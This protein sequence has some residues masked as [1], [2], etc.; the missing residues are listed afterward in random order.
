MKRF[1]IFGLIFVILISPKICAADAPRKIGEFV[2]G[3]KI[4]DHE[5]RVKQETVLPVRYLETLKEVEAK[6]IWGYKT[7]LIYYGTCIEPSR[8]VRIEFKYADYSIEFYEALL[9]RFKR[10]F[11]EPDEWRGDPFHIVIGWKW[12]FTDKDNN[13]ISLVL[14][15][16]IRDEEEKKGNYIKLTMWNLLGKEKRCYEKKHPDTSPA[17]RIQFR[18]R[19]PDSIDWENFIPQ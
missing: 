17:E 5:N 7:G 11:G 13:D 9:K 3:D 4:A 18:F 16:N 15:H 12:H 10:R 14:K 19:D 6:H 8:I 1:K 2:L